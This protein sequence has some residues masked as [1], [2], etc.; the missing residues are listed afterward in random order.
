MQ[1]HPFQLSRRSALLALPVALCLPRVGQAQAP[2]PRLQ[3]WPLN[4]P[5]A[6]G[7]HDLAPAPDGGVWFSAQRSGHLGWFD[8]RSGKSEL[9]PLGNGSS[10]HGVIAGPDGA[11]WLTDGG[12]NAMVRVSWPGREVKRFPLPAGTPYA[13]LNTCAFDGD[14]DLWFTGQSGYVG[15]VAVRSGAVSVKDS[16]RGPGPYGICATPRGDIWWCSLASNFIAQIDRKT[17]ESRVVEPPTPRQGARRVWS[18]SRGRIWVAEWNSGNLSVHDPALGSG[19]S[20]WRSWK[21]PGAAPQ[22]YAVYVDN[23]DMVWA[24]EW[25]HNAMLRFDAG[26]EKFE[27]IALPRPSANIRQILGRAGEVWLP[28]SGTEFISVIRTA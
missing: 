9:V 11:A 28:E 8:P 25:G 1:T 13:N 2:A 23:R 3:S 22:V 19:A 14:G 24:A 6:T 12:Q 20:S 15:K 5:R 21:A 18:D 4:T 16:P 17:G 27:V 26:S 10:P 7:I